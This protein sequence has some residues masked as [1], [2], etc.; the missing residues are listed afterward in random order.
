MLRT[1]TFAIV[2]VVVTM[3]V[4]L[5]VVV[6]GVLVLAF[7]Q[8]LFLS[9]LTKEQ[10]KLSPLYSYMRGDRM[11][12]SA[13]S[14]QENGDEQITILSLQVFIRGDYSHLWNHCAFLLLLLFVLLLSCFCF[15]F[16]RFQHV[17]KYVG[18]REKRRG[19]HRLNP[20][21]DLWTLIWVVRKLVSI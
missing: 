14:N 17:G 19:F 21:F 12:T 7:K 15:V 2:L 13:F 9:I 5:V 16:L 6:S 1:K 20:R 8:M 10:N 11:P 3:V 4:T 18:K